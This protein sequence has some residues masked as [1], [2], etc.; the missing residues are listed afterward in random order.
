MTHADYMIA[1]PYARPIPYTGKAFAAF[2]VTEAPAR[3]YPVRITGTPTNLDDALAE[4]IGT[5]IF[6]EK[7][8]IR[9]TDD[10]TG[11]TTLHLFAI[12]RKSAPDYVW[13]GN[14]QERVNRLYAEKVCEI[15]GG[16]LS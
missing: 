7:L 3:T 4:S 2:R 11:K 13:V 8:L 6:K 9:E 14:R 5:F 12:K 15:D 10:A 16:I 1:A